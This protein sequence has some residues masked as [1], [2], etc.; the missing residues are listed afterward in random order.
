MDGAKEG[1]KLAGVR[2][3]DAKKTVRWRQMFGCGQ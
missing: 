3:E 2:E 1:L